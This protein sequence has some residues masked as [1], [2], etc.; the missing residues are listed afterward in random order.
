MYGRFQ[1]GL[2]RFFALAFAT[3]LVAFLLLVLQPIEALPLIQPELYSTNVRYTANLCL[4][5]IGC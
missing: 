4:F 5:A 2:R 1:N 3:P